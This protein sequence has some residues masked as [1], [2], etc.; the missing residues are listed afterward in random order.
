MEIFSIINENTR[1][2]NGLPRKFYEFA[3]N[4]GKNLRNDKNTKQNIFIFSCFG[5]KL[6]MKLPHINKMSKKYASIHK[7]NENNNILGFTFANN[8]LIKIVNF[9][10]LMNIQNNLFDTGDSPL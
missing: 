2:Y 10:Y 9:N 8:E 3:R 4:D 1:E 7:L 5:E 6:A